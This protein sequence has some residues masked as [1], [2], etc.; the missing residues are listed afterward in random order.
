MTQIVPTRWVC[1]VCK[2]PIA[3]DGVIEI[4]N[5]NI[6]LGPVGAYPREPTEDASA[7]HERFMIELAKEKGIPREELLVITAEDLLSEEDPELNI[8]FAAR[9]IDCVKDRELQGYWIDT[10]SAN[11]L[12][13]WTAWVLHVQ[14]KNWMGREDLM[15]MLGFWW[16]HK[17]ERW[18]T[19]M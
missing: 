7:S 8:G 5:L 10:A 3:A 15:R 13:K 16:T 1:Q 12:E 17:G 2:K 4:I 9:H 6:D 14:E 19:G 18:P 11:T